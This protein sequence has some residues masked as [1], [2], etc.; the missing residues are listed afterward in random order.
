ME[1]YSVYQ[2]MASRTGGEMYIGVVGPVRTGKSTFIKR[3]METLVLPNAE[4]ADRAVM[5]DELPQS[6]PGRTV[7]TTEPKFVPAKAI[8]LS[9]GKG[10]KAS[11]RLVD[12][13]GFAVDGANG[14]EEDGKPRLVKTPWFDAPVPFEE[15]ASVG[16]E[17]VIREHST[18]GVL[19]T[20][21]GSFTDIERSAYQ[22]AE[23]RAAA[24][25]KSLGKPFVVVLNCV[26]PAAQE[27][28]RAELEREYDVPVVA[29]NVEKMTEQQALYTLQQALFEFPVTGVDVAV[30]AWLQSLP[31]ENPTVSRLLEK[32]KS[33]APEISKMKDCFKLENL[34]AD[35]DDF[36][37]PAGIELDL[38]KGKAKLFVD[39][40]DGLF[41]RVL[42]EACGE[43]IVNDCQLMAFVKSL[44]DAKRSYERFKGAIADAD[45]CGYGVVAPIVDEMN[46]E[47]PQLLKKG[48]NY[49]VKFR[50]QTASYH[51]IKVDVGGTVEP[52]VGGKAQGENFL[53]ETLGAYE[54]D[55]EKVWDTNIF[56]R[57]LKELFVEE[58]TG[59]SDAM[60][61]ELRAKMR[62]TV[63]RIVNEGKGGF[64]CI[65]I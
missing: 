50:A 22:K 55:T 45:E 39:V 64:F 56:G 37:N 41:Y 19:V 61:K 44:A 3:F 52:I 11:V 59:K 20:S 24:E 34:F 6:S 18:I 1:N 14:F 48:A 8:E 10:A 63:A 42:S 7:M 16:T 23:L 36:C 49:G 27:S 54:T 62:R 2:D 5:T 43:T 30:P 65:L 33:V 47:K 9:I 12:C 60:P 29:L 35:E 31:K 38:G 17:K 13:V 28:L 32:I 40:K 15:A 26:N 53:S 25:L 51:V 57:T 21:D 4:L 46:L 58:L